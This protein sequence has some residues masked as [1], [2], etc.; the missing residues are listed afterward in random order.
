MAISIII[1]INGLFGLN[2]SI[3]SFSIINSMEQT[4]RLCQIDV[5][6]TQL[7]VEI[8]FPC[9]ITYS[10][11]LG[12]EEIQSEQNSKLKDYKTSFS[13]KVTISGEIDYDERYLSKLG[14]LNVY[15]ISGSRKNIVGTLEFDIAE[16]L[17]GSGTV[18]LETQLIRCLDKNSSIK[19][20]INA[21]PLGSKL[22]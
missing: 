11:R 19:L 3:T 22:M 12:N 17:N 7:K 6:V 9:Q 10:V 20:R 18:E 8:R 4:K 13:N 21:R 2:C 14:I 15:V 16:I 5:Q 1:F